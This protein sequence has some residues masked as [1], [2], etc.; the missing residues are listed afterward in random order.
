LWLCL[1]DKGEIE[2]IWG[3]LADPKEKEAEL[4]VRLIKAGYAPFLVD[5][6]LLNPSQGRCV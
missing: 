1:P 4:R 2:V 3:G 5:V 6:A